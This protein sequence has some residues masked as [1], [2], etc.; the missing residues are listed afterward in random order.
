MNEFLSKLQTNELSAILTTF[1]SRNPNLE[2]DKQHHSHEQ[3]LSVVQQLHTQHASLLQP[4][5]QEYTGKCGKDCRSCTCK[6]TRKSN[7]Q[8]E[9]KNLKMFDDDDENVHQKKQRP[10][11]RPLSL[12]ACVSK[13]KKK[14]SS[15]NVPVSFKKHQDVFNILKENSEQVLIVYNVQKDEFSSSPPIHKKNHHLCHSNH[16]DDQQ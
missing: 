13:R 10:P 6:N 15:S 11:K 14:M 3:L 8:Q 9:W 1:C 7:V 12:C 16:Q 2:N 4:I 5:L